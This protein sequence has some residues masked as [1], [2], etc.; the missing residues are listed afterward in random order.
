MSNFNELAK[1]LTHEQSKGL[2]NSSVIGGLE[3]FVEKWA[4]RTRNDE[5]AVTVQQILDALAGYAQADAT[6]RNLMIQRA[7]TIAR[8]ADAFT[9]PTRSPATETAS[10][11]PRTSTPQREDLS[12]PP[13][14]KKSSQPRVEHREELTAPPELE[15]IPE[16][17]E[18]LDEEPAYVAPTRMDFGLDADVSRLQGVGKVKAAQLE[19]LGV[20]TVR[21]LLYHFPRAY[22][23]VKRISELMY[24][25]DATV[26]CQVSHINSYQTRNGFHI[27]D[28]V[29]MDPTGGITAK[30]FKQPWVA[31]S[32]RPRQFIVVSGKVDRD[33][34][35]LSFKS[36]EY[37]PLTKELQRLLDAARVYPVYPLTEGIKA[38]WLRKTERGVVGFWADKVVDPLPSA[39]RA[40]ANLMPLSTALREIH[41]PSSM[42]TMAAARHR[43]AFEELLYIQLGVFRQRRKW[44]QEPSK[45]LHIEPDFLA[46]F[47]SGLPYALTGAQ[48]RAIGEIFHDIQESAPMSRLLQG[49]VGAGKTVVAA[50]ALLVAVM[51]QSQAVLMAPTEIL[52]EQHYKTIT[53]ILPALSEHLR[54]NPRVKLLIGSMKPREKQQV[55]QEIAAGEVDIAIGTHALIQEAVNFPKLTLAVIDEQHRFGVE[56]RAMLRQKGQDGAEIRPHILVMSATPIPR[57]LALTVYGDLDLSILDEMPPGRTPIMTKWLEP[58]ER[59]R[60]YSFIRKQVGE[61]RQA[62]VICPLIE[63]SETIDARA[64]VEEYE[65]LRSQV[66]P[67]L[68]VGLIHGKLRP[69]EK[70]AVMEEFRQAQIDVL[71]ATSVVEVGIDV[72]NATVMLIEGADRFGLA[73]LHQFRGRIGRGAYQSYCMLLADK[74]GSTSDDRLKVIEGTQDGFKLAEADL[75]LRGP[76]EFFGTR[77]SGLPDLKVAQLT[78]VKLLEQAR[79]VA[80]EIFDQDPELRAPENQ[81]LKKGMQEFWHG[82]GDLS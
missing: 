8:Q 24:G 21:D 68:R 63:E 9:K 4:Q 40:S 18:E 25:D 34:N 1:I 64:A 58:K 67:D 31:K 51:N 37:E 14:E 77:Q 73:Q 6:Q 53:T 82:E 17:D 47:E 20:T 19:R 45:A 79:E 65:R 2:Q 5:N 23:P 52:A 16:E 56:Q 49:D 32:L 74:S 60:A 11:T 66:Y 35:K 55:Q 15:P 3:P 28:V 50:A 30:F 33:L 26:I 12:R 48:K 54:V 22:R 81:L 70:D 7:V 13:S 38:N 39:L 69:A 78:D 27:T 10:R 57:T 59:E 71:V 42:E 41:F 36:P 76:G 61:G 43:F 46:R 72:P 75:L 29:L 62:F 80:E 44:R